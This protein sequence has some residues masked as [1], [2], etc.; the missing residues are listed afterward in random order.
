MPEVERKRMQILPGS[1]ELKAALPGLALVVLPILIISEVIYWI[2]LNY[3]ES[4]FHVPPPVIALMIAAV[5]SIAIT[6]LIELP[7]KYRSG[8]Q[9]TTRWLLRIGI[10]LYGFNFSYALWFKT[11]SQW[12]LVIGLVAVALPLIAGYFIG[13][14]LK[15]GETSSL[16]V[17]V[18][19]AICGISAIVATQ[20]AVGADEKEAGASIATILVF[21][22]LVVFAYPVIDQLLGLSGV[23]Y[24][25]WTGAT[26][27]DLPQ[28]V[29]AALQGGGSASLLSALWVKSI[30]I[31]LLVPVILILVARTHRQMGHSPNEKRGS[32]YGAVLKSFPLFILAFFLVILYN[33][34]F[35]LP[36]WIL[37]PISSGSGQYLNLNAASLLLTTAIIGIC[38]NVRRKVISGTG[39]KFIVVGGIIWGLQ[40]LIVLWLATSLNL[41]DSSGSQIP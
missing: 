23:I 6:N 19:T 2:E 30:R 3:V 34:V 8:L 17:A 5:L 14:L 1:G 40:S 27:L 20:Q 24:G 18:G 26:T 25:V 36:T 10:V 4:F 11:G 39:W 37:G 38:F 33:T 21:G 32:Q 15:L 35:P 9:F 16:L 41:P 7:Q 13:G 31:G 28:L 29:T 12:I 22:T